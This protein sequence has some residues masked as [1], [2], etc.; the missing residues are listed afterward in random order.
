M[1]AFTITPA[2]LY[3]PLY[4]ILC[5]AD[6][7][8]AAAG[9]CASV[10]RR[11]GPARR[12][13]GR[14]GW[15]LNARAYTAILCLN[16][17]WRAG[18]GGCLRLHGV[19]GAPAAAAAAAAAPAVTATTAAA[20]AT[21]AATTTTTITAAARV[22]RLTRVPRVTSR[23]QAAGGGRLVVPSN[24]RALH[25]MLQVTRRRR[26]ESPEAARSGEHAD[27]V[28]PVTRRRDPRRTP[29]PRG[30]AVRGR[31]KTPSRCGR[32]T[33]TS[34]S[35]RR[36]HSTHRLSTPPSPRRQDNTRRPSR[37]RSDI[38]PAGLRGAR[39]VYQPVALPRAT[40]HDPLLGPGR[41]RW[42]SASIAAAFS[43]ID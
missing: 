39:R 10:G 38:A 33:P 43:T 1:H 17:S 19:K 5:C 7:S 41:D 32:W 13:V 24:Q 20:T 15:C 42:H 34:P 36:R 8:D 26:R 22:Q 28:L 31:R 4:L 16:Y 40:S 9:P 11:R 30:V 27:E 14:V 29:R 6:A 2:I 3:F 18:H 25:A 37:G 21:T 23:R 35:G 12:S